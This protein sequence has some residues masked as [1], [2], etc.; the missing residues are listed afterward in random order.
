M[1]TKA[2]VA[3]TAAPVSQAWQLV[4]AMRPRQWAKNLLIYLAF[5]FTLGQHGGDGVVDDLSLFGKAT[6]GL[7]LFSL[8]SGATYLLNDLMDIQGDRL[9]PTKRLRPLASGRLSPTVATASAAVFTGLAIGLGFVL[10]IGFGVV[11]VVYL[12][13]TAAY[14]F[15]LKNMVILDVM[16]VAGGFVLRAAAGALVIGA[17]ISPWLYVMTS[18]GALLISFGKRRSELAHLGEAGAGHRRV[19]NDYSIAFLDQLI[20]VVAPATVLAYT[21]YTFT[22]ENLPEDDS[23]M[24]TVPF[25]LYGVFRY[26]FLLHKSNM[27][28]SPE[29]IFLTDYPMLANIMLWLATASAILLI[30]R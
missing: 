30:A 20:V 1:Q 28:G 6:L 25:V 26:L 12:A 14:T 9:H 23:M 18:L 15:Q 13:L 8:L 10:D 7:V 3:G 21:L 24:L 19:L 2:V 29:E 5:F 11:T 22:A 16:A 27:A 4:L 17:P